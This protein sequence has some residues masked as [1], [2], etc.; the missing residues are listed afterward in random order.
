MMT[1][2]VVLRGNAYSEIESSGA[3]AAAQL[4][5]LHPDRVTPLWAPDK[6]VV[7]EYRPLDDE[8]RI[9][10]QGEMC[11]IRGLS[12]NGLTGMDPI[13]LAR[14]AL[15][16]SIAAET[17][18]AT[19]F[20]NGTVIGGVLEH[21][22]ALGDVAYERLKKSWNERHQGAGMAHKPALLEEGMKWQSIG[23]EP[24]KAQFLETRKFQITEIAR[25][26]RVPPHM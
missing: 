22:K 15:G 1:G 5:P 9:I 16:I 11:H 19:Y 13:S 7:Y 24:E 17:F 10:L 8:P 18:G 6:T 14:E 20:G 4:I 23:V 25:M 2:H 21:P 12:S 26:F 3:N